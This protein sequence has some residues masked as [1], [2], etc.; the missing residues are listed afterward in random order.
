MGFGFGG[1]IAL[2]GDKL[3]GDGLISGDGLDGCAGV[4]MVFLVDIIISSSVSIVVFI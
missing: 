1:S 3:S 2:S 4:G